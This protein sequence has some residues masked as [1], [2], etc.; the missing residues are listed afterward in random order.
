L[1]P[2]FCCNYPDCNG[3]PSMAKRRAGSLA[4]IFLISKPIKRAWRKYA[5]P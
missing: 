4:I 1:L 2:D 5:M 3:A